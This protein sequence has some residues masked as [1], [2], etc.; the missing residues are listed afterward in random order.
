MKYTKN[1]VMKKRNNLSSRQIRRHSKISLFLFK[2]ILIISIALIA[3]FL[4]L[5]I[6]F[7]RGVLKPHRRLRKNPSIQKGILQPFMT[8]MAQRLKHFPT[9]IPIKSIPLCPKCRRT[10]RMH[11]LQLKMKDS[12]HITELTCMALCALPSLV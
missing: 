4:G 8:T 1:N 5:S 7:V 2:Y 11:L 6:G 9:M 3:A 10:C 12:I